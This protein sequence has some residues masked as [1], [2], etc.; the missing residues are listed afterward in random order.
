M[1]DNWSVRIAQ[2]GVS[3]EVTRMGS[4]L[5][6]KIESGDGEPTGLILRRSTAQMLLETL[7]TALANEDE[8]PDG[9]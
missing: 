5:G 2:G 4:M 9:E 1:A 3:V 6:V 7:A 8:W